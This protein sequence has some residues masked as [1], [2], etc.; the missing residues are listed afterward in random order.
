MSTVESAPPS[1]L[2]FAAEQ[3]EPSNE[4][5]EEN[6]YAAAEG[7]EDWRAAAHE[8]RRNQVGTPELWL[9]RSA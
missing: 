5:L 4:H 7:F 1:W 6:L 3:C 9:P 2:R 8:H